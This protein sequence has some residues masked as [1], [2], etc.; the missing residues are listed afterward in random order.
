MVEKQNPDRFSSYSWNQS[1]LDRLFG[2]P[3]HGP[4]SAPLW[5]VAA[6]HGD[7]CAVAD[8]P[9]ATRTLLAAVCRKGP[10]P[11]RNL[12]NGARSPAPPSGSV[13]RWLP[14]RRRTYR[15]ATA[16][17]STLGARLARLGCRR[18]ICHPISGDRSSTNAREG[19]GM[20][21]CPSIGPK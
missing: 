1:A 7:R 6:D 8:Y 16:T 5:R 15:R 9:P 20:L 11:G 18:S 10:G 3:S 19:G 14:P 4:P 2:H 17:V 21:A 13:A 12:R